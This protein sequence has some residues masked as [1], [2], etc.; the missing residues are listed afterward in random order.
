MED[1]E[2]DSNPPQETA[3]Q[4]DPI[5]KEMENKLGVDGDMD[6]MTPSGNQPIM[7]GVALLPSLQKMISFW[8]MR[9]KR[10]TKLEL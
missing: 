2:D 3:T 6:L 8:S 9:M 7:E 10:R 5:A 4:T 1:I